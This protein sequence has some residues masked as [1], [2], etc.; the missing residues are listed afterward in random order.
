[1]RTARVIRIMRPKGPWVRKA[2]RQKSWSWKRGRHP[3]VIILFAEALSKVVAEV[4]SNTLGAIS[5]RYFSPILFPTSNPSVGIHSSLNVLLQGGGWPVLRPRMSLTVMVL[6]TIRIQNWDCKSR[7]FIQL[8]LSNI[9][10]LPMCH[11]KFLINFANF[12][13]ILQCLMHSSTFS[14][15][16]IFYVNTI[17][18]ASSTVIIQG[19]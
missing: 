3:F 7:Y 16:T 19:V 4:H 11:W 14:V 18:Y 13:C 17:H 2:S 12:S 5:S 9:I 15:S 1:M 10:S 8:Q 6:V